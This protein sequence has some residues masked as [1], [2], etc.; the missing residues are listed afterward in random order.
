MHRGGTSA[1]AGM[2]H[3][4]GVDFG[5]QLMPANADNPAGYYEHNDVV[6]LHDRFLGR[7]GAGWDDPFPP[8]FDPGVWPD[9]APAPGL[10]TY[11]QE[12]IAIL[13]RDFTGQGGRSAAPLW[14][15]KDPRLCLLLP[16]W[17]PLWTRLDSEPRFI[18]VL[19]SP[20]AVAA[21][22]GRRDGFSPVKSQL[23]WL[24]HVLRA[25][26]DTRGHRRC[27]LGYDD[28]L[29]DWRGTIERVGT[30]LGITWPRSPENLTP[31]DAAFIDPVLRHH[32]V[33]S[34]Q[35]MTSERVSK[36]CLP[37][38]ETAQANFPPTNLENTFILD[39]LQKE[40]RQTQH[41]F[42]TLWV[43]QEADLTRQLHAHRRL[44]CW[45]EEEWQKALQEHHAL[46]QRL[47]KKE[48]KILQLQEHL[49]K[50]ER[51]RKHK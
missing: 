18:I 23:L 11:R 8:E 49:A 17:T 3:R 34:S 12:L 15:L 31:S 38:L 27:F 43:H 33:T 28:F 2:L 39:A 10:P 26:R 50:H 40:M 22:L 36:T 19:R 13:Q 14:G 51:L 5:P 20:D 7:L 6:N 4:L 48:A 16:W 44:T 42:S 47:L 21:S 1:V 37:W 24:Q 41:I 45:Y 25:E 46:E 29:T 35:D 9:L 32:H 30:A